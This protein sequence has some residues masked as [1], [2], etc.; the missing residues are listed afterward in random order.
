MN[1]TK[2]SIATPHH[3]ATAAGQRVYASGGNAIDA[4]IAAAAVLTVVYPHMCALGGDAQALLVSPGMPVRALGGSGAAARAVNA[5]ALRAVHRDMPLHGVHPIT[6]PGL[7]AAWGDLHAAGGRLPWHSLFDEAISLADGGTTVSSALGRDLQA[8]GS[9]LATDP[10][11]RA[12]FFGNDGCVLCAGQTLRQPALAASLSAISDNGARE[13]YEGAL[14]HTLVRGLR[15]L[16]ASLDDEDFAGHRSEWLPPLRGS[17]AGL[18]VLTSPPV[19]Q[20]FVLLQL[21]AALQRADLVGADPLGPAAATL[22]RLCALTAEACNN[23]LADPRHVELD[24]EAWLSPQ[25]I[26]TLIDVAKNSRSPLS[27][28]AP[29]PRPDGDTVAVAT[30]DA[31]GFAVSLIQSVFHAFGAGVLEPC[32]GIVCHN[33]GAAFTLQQGPAMLVGGRRPPSTL[34]PAILLRAGKPQATIGTMGGRGQP[35][36]LAQLLTRLAAGAAPFDALAAPRWVV[37][38]FG[39]MGET[40]VLVESLAPESAREVL[41]ASGLPVMTGA[42]RDDRAGHAQFVWC[43][44]D[45]ALASATDPR[46]DG[47]FEIGS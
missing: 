32:T 7:V 43:N 23:S 41:L 11:M 30:Q 25:Y 31:D 1:A 4:A 14:A 5:A 15:A 27:S 40:M 19:S 8:L 10:G 45:G 35:Q 39:A 20:G 18:D 12:V 9:R 22:A 36:I 13:L 33:R 17:F 21:L 6:V 38:G 24:L 3:K 28:A 47:Q 42:A 16:G 44:G 26:D 29:R 46:S 37:G 2:G 34:T